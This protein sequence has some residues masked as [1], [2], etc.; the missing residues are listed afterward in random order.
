MRSATRLHDHLDVV[1]ER[2]EEAL[3][4][5]SRETLPIGD[6]SNPICERH[7]EHTFR[8]IDRNSRSLHHG[9]LLL[10]RPYRGLPIAF[11]G[12]HCKRPDERGMR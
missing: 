11:R 12:G 8:E 6:A 4:L 3:E 1:G 9:S 10:A 5:P 2:L 7:L